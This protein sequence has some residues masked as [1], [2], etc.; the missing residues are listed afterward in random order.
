MAST[1]DRT[2][3]VHLKEKSLELLPYIFITHVIA[4]RKTLLLLFVLSTTGSYRVFN[5]MDT[6][7]CSVVS[8]SSVMSVQNY[9]EM[10][11]Q[12]LI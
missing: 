9:H 3:V 10:F 7:W 12:R 1:S 5:L 4:N 11:P 8:Y 6:V 2:V